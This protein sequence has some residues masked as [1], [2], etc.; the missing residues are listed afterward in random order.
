MT[1]EDWKI[2]DV[3][4]VDGLICH[5]L[6]NDDRHCLHR[7][8]LLRLHHATENAQNQIEDIAHWIALLLAEK[9]FKGWGEIIAE[10]AILTAIKLR[11]LANEIEK[12]IPVLARKREYADAQEA[13]AGLL[14]AGEGTAGSQ[15]PDPSPAGDWDD[16]PF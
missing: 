15:P 16:V 2:L 13:A 5:I 14:G 12:S 7:V 3:H 9:D 10:N 11:V 4:G 6:P 1:P 8:A